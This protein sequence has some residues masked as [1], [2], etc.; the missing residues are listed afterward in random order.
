M[1]SPW[2][3]FTNRKPQPELDLYCLPYAGGNASLY[4]Q[5]DRYFPDW[6]AVH[7]VELPGRG[8]RICETLEQEPAVLAERL[9]DA[10]L[11]RRTRPFALL[12][13][14]MGGGLAFHLSHYAERRGRSPT[15]IFVAGRQAP[16]IGSRRNR[17][18]MSDQALIEELRFLNGSPPELFEHPELMALM[19]PI[20]RA[21]F[22]LSERMLNGDGDKRIHTPIHV[23]GSRDDPEV[24][25]RHLMRWQ[26]NAYATIRLSLLEGGHFFIHDCGAEIAS[27]ATRD[28]TLIAHPAHREG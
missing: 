25:H 9:F 27:L 13:H 18:C 22:T 26:E 12:G 14:S 17:L 8:T 28:M 11:A 6:I 3:P 4:S 2:L 5:W 24:D 19:L 16:I 23:I 10:L 1:T 21:D 15:Q 7:P 20:V